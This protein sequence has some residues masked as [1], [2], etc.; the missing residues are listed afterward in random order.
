M[1]CFVDATDDEIYAYIARFGIEALVPYQ[2]GMRVS[3]G[4]QPAT[5]LPPPAAEARFSVDEP[6][7][8]A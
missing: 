1:R 3:A 5:S 2:V 6:R 4:P 8:A 7:R